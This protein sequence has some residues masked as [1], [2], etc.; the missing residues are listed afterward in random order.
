MK[1]TSL[2]SIALALGAASISCSTNP[3]AGST[4]PVG[5]GCP[6]GTDCT[7]G[8]P[9]T[10][11]TPGTDPFNIPPT[12]GEV[13]A[14]GGTSPYDPT[15]N[16]SS[17]VKVDTATN[18]IVIDQT[19]IGKGL[20]DF[21]WIANSGEGTESKIDT[22][23]MKQVARYCTY[24]GCNGDPSRSTVS[25]LGDVAVANRANYYGIRGNPDRA[26]V[27][28]IAGDK[29]RCVDRNN[30][31]VIDTFEGEGAVPAAFRW[32]ANQ[33]DSPDECVLWLTKLNKDRTGNTGAGGVDGT[34]PRAASFDSTIAAD[35][36]PSQYL[37][38]GLFNT[39]EVVRIDSKTGAILKQFL[40]NA[41]PYGFVTDKDG[42]LWIRGAEGSLTKVDVKN[43]DTV[44]R[45]TGTQAPPC[46]YGISA[47]SRGYIYT[48]GGN[49]VSRFNPANPGANW[50]TL[51]IGGQPGNC[52][53]G[54]GLA[55]DD[56]FNL[57]VADTCGGINHVDASK[58]FGQGMT[59]K[60]VVAPRG[61][62]VNFYY[63]GIGLDALAHPWVVSTGSSDL[64]A[65]GAGAIGMVYHIDPA[66]YAAAGV[67]TGNAPYTYSD[68]TGAQL[69]YAGT[70]FG[71]YRHTFKSNCA[72]RK[73][74]WTEV[75][76][77]VDTP[78][79]TTIEVSSR[80]G[81]DATS[82][83]TA[84]FSPATII[85]P[86]AAGPIKP[87]LNEGVDN[88]FLQLQFKLTADNPTVTP[89]V[90]NLKAKYICG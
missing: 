77:D 30:N 47:D 14:G 66:T 40:V 7:G 46:P 29:S 90:K 12:S 59:F 44:T 83:E 23:T 13:T 61:A 38:I 42:T 37:Y 74:T 68:M 45:Y 82:L 18:A 4:I 22:K 31:G 8:T 43:N 10:P 11:G 48:A 49:C 19:A 78:T 65:G 39:Q 58:A 6:A 62:G 2:L 9:G 15:A 52:S 41:Q 17:G 16:G 3:T 56:K 84:L 63:L 33:T 87:S 89:T 27:V 70:R 76:Y 71:L 34:L 21:I 50:E 67:Q 85:P 60:R 81:A 54:R 24:P 32:P 28:K 26:S 72:P 57:W 51:V 1:T 73:T 80:G 64:G 55:L 53:S 25:L 20:G 5:Q 69:R 75:T 36:T 86:A 79:G 35:G 88:T